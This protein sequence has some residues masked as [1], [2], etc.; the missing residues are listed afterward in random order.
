MSAINP[1]LISEGVQDEFRR[2]I[3]TSFPIL[4]PALKAAVDQRIEAE[5]L[6][7]KGP[8]VTLRPPLRRTVNVK[9]LVD[10]GLLDQGVLKPFG[11]LEL[12]AHQEN[13]IRL[14]AG[15]KNLLLS[16]G[17]GSGKTEA[18]LI[19]I[20]DHCLTTKANRDNPK[21][22]GVKALI[23]Y[24]MNAL[25]NDQLKR[26]REVLAGTGVTFGRLSGETP[27]DEEG[28]PSDIPVE[29]RWSRTAIR[30]SPPD[31]LLT[32]YAML[33]QV[34][35]RHDE[36]WEVFESRLLKFIVLDE[37]HTF[38][39]ARGVDVAFLVRRV[40]ER[41][42]RDHTLVQ[43]AGTSATLARGAGTEDAE[44]SREA[45]EAFASKIFGVQ[46][47]PEEL[48]VEE[49][50]PIDETDAR[51]R[52]P[53]PKGLAIED[54][55]V[56]TPQARVKLVAK[57][58]GRPVTSLKDAVE[59]V[60]ASVAFQEIVTR[61]REGGATLEDLSR[62]VAKSLPDREKVPQDQREREVVTYLL[63]GA[64]LSTGRDPLLK[65][66]THV[67]YR[68]IRDFTRCI[69]PRCGELHADGQDTCRKCH[70][71]ALP[72]E[73][74]RS[75]GQDFLRSKPREPNLAAGETTGVLAPYDEQ[76]DEHTI[77]LAPNG[78]HSPEANEEY[79]EEEPKPKGNA[80]GKQDTKEHPTFACTHCG[81][82]STPD[83]ERR[84]CEKGGCVGSVHRYPTWS[85]RILSCPGCQG[86]YGTQEVVTLFTTATSASVS[87]LTRALLARLPEA[88][89]R[90]LIFADNRQDTAYQAGYL[91][92]RHRQ[93]TIRQILYRAIR[94][95]DKSGQAGHDVASLSE[96][97]LKEAIKIGIERPEENPRDRER[98]RRDLEWEVLREFFRKGNRRLSLEGLGLVEV[99]FPWLADHVAADER[100]KTLAQQCGGVEAV[101]QVFEATL[102]EMRLNRA[103]DHPD[104]RITPDA[105]TARQR[106]L[107]PDETIAVGYDDARDYRRDYKV[108][109]FFT[110]PGQTWFMDFVSRQ[111]LAAPARDF[112]ATMIAVLSDAGYIVREQIGRQGGQ[113][114]LAWRVCHKKMTFHLPEHLWRC[115]GCRRFHT[116]HFAACPAFRCRGA[117]RDAKIDEEN[118]YVRTYRDGDPVKVIPAEHSGQLGPDERQAA[119]RDFRDGTRNVLVCTPTMELGVN[120]GELATVLM[121]NAPPNPANYV[122]RAGRAGR[123]DG[124]IALVNTFTQ[125][126]AHDIHFYTEPAG[127]MSGQI[128]APTL[129]LANLH[130]IKRQARSVL[131]SKLET[132]LPQKL[133]EIIDHT[134]GRLRG[135]NAVLSEV[136]GRAEDLAHVIAKV[137]S[138]D[139][140][141][142]VT[143][144]WA[145][146][147]VVEPFG[148]DLQLAFKPL[149][150]KFESLAT[151]L[152]NIPALALDDSTERERRQLRA[153]I[154][155][156]FGRDREGKDTQSAVVAR[157]LQSVGFLPGYGFPGESIILMAGDRL[158]PI[159][160]DA[161]IA[162]TEFAPHNLLYVAGSRYSV[163]TLTLDEMD[164]HSARPPLKFCPKCDWVEPSPDANYCGKCA[165][166]L[167]NPKDWVS[168]LGAFASYRGTVTSEEEARQRSGYETSTHRLGETGFESWR[169]TYTG[170]PY[171]ING[172]EIKDGTVLFVNH[173][174]LSATSD[175]PEPFL[176]HRNRGSVARLD[177]AERVARIVE[178]HGGKF[179]RAIIA[180][181]HVSDLFI[182][183]MENIPDELSALPTL[184]GA[185]LLAARLHI[186]A[187]EGE[188]RAFTQR[189]G[190]EKQPRELVFYENIPGGVG[191]LSPLARDL[192]RVARRALDH[193]TNCPCEKSCYR[194]LKTYWNQQHHQ[195]LD[196]RLVLDALRDLAHAGSESEKVPLPPGA[197][198]APAPAGEHKYDS[199]AEENVARELV[200]AGL[201]QPETG[202][203]IATEGGVPIA[204]ADLAYTSKRVAIFIDGQAY[205]SDARQRAA[206]EE[207]RE[208]LEDLGWKVRR[209]PYSKFREEPERYIAKLKR[210][211]EGTD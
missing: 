204:R 203:M 7:W 134:T 21:I 141:L 155:R 81:L 172:R 209:I 75:C 17:T 8:F 195:R 57:V 192:P 184:E 152:Q 112:A 19:P 91:R 176:V 24:P 114:R 61:L 60:R 136:E 93:F 3:N 149:L 202:V 34:L 119:E 174:S 180:Y 142:G 145:F 71:L 66:Q 27:Y 110:S 83:R 164:R 159:T 5:S 58:L 72:L 22:R 163:D 52:T 206:D 185:L 44:R 77:H 198:A 205:H 86:R 189:L 13:A 104:L 28:K 99:R 85:G 200:Q 84:A 70:G 190:D 170:A 37:V 162:L 103:A 64:T 45:L 16:S 128:R 150:A 80:K 127:M 193:L 140:G 43:C 144:A 171:G 15:G 53:F 188:L 65:I 23:I 2:Y 130:L 14:L 102:H 100:V 208:A 113:S 143:G 132:S 106:R 166:K 51:D 211:I 46:F 165:E 63:L 179:D 210:A 126:T 138:Q 168:P 109:G 181:P 105:M 25:A 41:A 42:S 194:C 182:I 96:H 26:L 137:F 78:L 115:T 35:I 156:L 118:L 92:D 183:R 94:E 4:D 196:K 30:N 167:D 59:S 11:K 161:A 108:R 50:L 31:I 160:R 186:D 9:A 125:P 29:E 122:Q 129:N 148:Q 131:L 20:V 187:N 40:K 133:G 82:L 139:E 39:G 124:A 207:Q 38:T 89:R 12:Y 175:E 158:D 10:E 1:F 135:I 87:V 76:T 191:Y 18:F 120:I 47:T 169:H 73:V 32:N 95:A 147:H 151:R 90:L 157:Y 154:N 55:D 201:P 178:E 177:D 111:K 68:G 74:C 97:L 6:L 88:Q 146:Q 98:K 123:T 199:V 67:W 121:R 54:L 101:L 79:E 62:A 116:K 48:V 117:L 49:P 36:H 107:L 197:N 33:E 173:G 69:D 153:Q 56:S